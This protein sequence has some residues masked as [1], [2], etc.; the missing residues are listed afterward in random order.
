MQRL[1]IF[2]VALLIVLA[3]ALLEH[4]YAPTNPSTNSPVACTMEAKLCPD[5]SYVGRQPPTCEFS[6]CPEPGT[7]SI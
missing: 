7:T 3:T 4:K 2:I 6:P 1:L 5:G